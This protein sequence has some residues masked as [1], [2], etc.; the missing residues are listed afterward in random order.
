MIVF[1][2]FAI[3]NIRSQFFPDVPIEKINIGVKWA[4]AGPEEIDDGVVS[5]LEAP[6][7]GIDSVE[8]IISSSTEGNARIYLDFKPGT[9]YELDLVNYHTVVNN[10]NLP[11]YDN[12]I[13]GDK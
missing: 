2:L 3:N 7:L 9:A 6:L 10:S 4:G 5:L 1:G 13:H 8:Q 11:R 12:I